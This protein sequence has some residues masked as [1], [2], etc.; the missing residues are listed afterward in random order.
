MKIALLGN[1]KTGKY[2]SELSKETLI[3][4]SKNK[5]TAM[6][7][8]QCDVVICFVSSEVIEEYIDELIISKK[9]VVIASTGKEY[10]NGLNEKLINSGL[11]WIHSSNF[12]KSLALYKSIIQFLSTQKE[13]ITDMKINILDIHHKDKQ[14]AP[15]GTALTIK[16]W[17]GEEVLI[18]S[19][20]E[21]D[22][23]GVHSFIIS[24]EVEE[25]SI[26]HTIKDRSVFAK[27]AINAACILLKNHLGPGLHQFY[28][29][30]NE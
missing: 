15:S 3:F 12:S 26:T 19:I 18:R 30:I 5:L 29:V 7:I 23:V 2:I 20:R 24:N 22:H 21:D 27:G 28:E 9:P 8:S 16:D 10:I 25:I 11:T 6:K 17:Y 4:D 14:D 1:G 13:Y